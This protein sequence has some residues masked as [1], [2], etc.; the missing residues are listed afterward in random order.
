ML[1]PRL[2][3]LLCLCLTLLPEAAFY[4]WQRASDPAIGMHSHT[5]YPRPYHTRRDNMTVRSRL[6]NSTPWWGSYSWVALRVS[7]TEPLISCGASA[8]VV[9][10]ELP[11]QFSGCHPASSTLHLLQLSRKVDGGV[12][13]WSCTLGAPICVVMKFMSWFCQDYLNFLAIF[14]W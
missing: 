13:A 2:Q 7:L 8:V 1:I 5:L 3:T 4:R 6:L 9:P 11:S 12:F 14:I 10:V